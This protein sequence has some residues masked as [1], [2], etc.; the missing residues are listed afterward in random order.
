MT[1]IIAPIDV[2]VAAVAIPYKWGYQDGLNGEDMQGS[3]FF[4]G[5]SLAQY[6]EGYAAGLAKRKINDTFEDEKTQA[7]IEFFEQALVSLRA[8]KVKPLAYMT[9]E[10]LEEIEDEQIG[11]MFSRQPF[12]F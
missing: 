2:E 3:A 12:L 8:G 4:A 11:E 6:N 10:T 5:C 9:N 1:T 7:E